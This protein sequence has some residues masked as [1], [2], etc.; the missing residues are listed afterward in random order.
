[1]STERFIH[2][3]NEKTGTHIVGNEKVAGQLRIVV[4]FAARKHA[5]L[6]L[7]ING[8]HAKRISF[9]GNLSAKIKAARE[10]LARCE[11]DAPFLR[12]LVDGGIAQHERKAAEARAQV[13]AREL[14]A[15]ELRNLKL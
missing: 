3:R 12:D 9:T 4:T 8:V 13:S 6:E 7:R 14:L 15:Q 11:S 1:M 2:T 10:L 5:A